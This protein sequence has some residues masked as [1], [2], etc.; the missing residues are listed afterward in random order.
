[1]FNT[2]VLELPC[3]CLIMEAVQKALARPYLN[4]YEPLAVRFSEEVVKVLDL[5]LLLLAQSK[6][7]LEITQKLQEQATRDGL[8]QVSNRRQFDKVLRQEWQRLRRSRQPLALIHCDVDEFKRYNDTYG[9]QAGDICLQSVAQLMKSAIKRPS[10][11]VARYG[12]EE[13][14]LLLPDTPLEGAQA[15]AE[16]LRQQLQQKQIPHQASRVKP[17]V[18]VSLGISCLIP[19][20]GVSPEML[21]QQA[22]EALYEAKKQGRDRAVVYVG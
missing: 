19:T 7:F 10:D 4:L 9:H 11:F 14:V 2:T 13:F 3:D 12:G 18:T 1:M 21:V 17:W 20:G 15:V 8:T 22:D 16:L 6:L 5:H